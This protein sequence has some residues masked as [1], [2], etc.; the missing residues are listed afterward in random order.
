MGET[1]TTATGDIRSR[2]KQL[3]RLG[4][5]GVGWIGRNR[6]EVIAHSRMAEIAVICDP[7][8]EALQQSLALAP[9]AKTVSSYD[10][11]LSADIN[12]V[13]IATSSAQCRAVIAGI[14]T[15]ISRVLPEA[16]WPERT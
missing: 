9:T 5:L 1:L 7:S 12:G 16:A 4:F 2:K 6:L 3:P 11:L 15:W 10:E 8:P 13:I 14:G